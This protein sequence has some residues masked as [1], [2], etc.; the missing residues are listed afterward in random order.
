MLG[1]YG[2]DPELEPDAA[3]I[4]LC[5]LCRLAREAVVAGDNALALK[6]YRDVLAEFPQDTVARELIARLSG[7][8]SPRQIVTQAAK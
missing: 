1:A 2:V 6:R 7:G 3:T 8:S 4:R 5:R